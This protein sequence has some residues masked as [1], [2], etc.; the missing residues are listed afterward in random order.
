MKSVGIIKYPTDE[1]LFTSVE[2]G[3]RNLYPAQVDQDRYQ[4][5]GRQII[6]AAIYMHFIDASIVGGASRAFI[7]SRPKFVM[8]A[9]FESRGHK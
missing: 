7:R 4:E 8:T 1:N 6:R 9:I 2:R 5:E 3:R